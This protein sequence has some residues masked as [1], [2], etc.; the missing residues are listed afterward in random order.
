M[1]KHLLL[2]K[3]PSL[4]IALKYIFI[5]YN[6]KFG[7]HRFCTFMLEKAKNSAVIFYM[8]QLIQSTRTS[9]KNEVEKY[10]IKK[11]KVSSRV[12]HQFLWSLEV[13]HISK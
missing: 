8:P 11:C 5:D 3:F 9:T 12:A 1:M 2:W 13:E 10:I 7:L 6:N 4:N